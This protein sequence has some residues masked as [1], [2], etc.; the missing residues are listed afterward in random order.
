MED[1]KGY[2]SRFFV[3]TTRDRATA[4]LDPEGHVEPVSRPEQ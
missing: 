2:Y 1:K 3:Y 4:C